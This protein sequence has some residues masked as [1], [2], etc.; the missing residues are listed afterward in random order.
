M[1]E[2]QA[3]REVWNQTAWNAYTSCLS[4][5]SCDNAQSCIDQAAA[6]APEATLDR[7]LD[8]VCSWASRCAGGVLSPSQCVSMLRDLGNSTANQNDA[9]PWNAVRLLQTSAVDCMSHCVTSLSCAQTDFGKASASC[10]AQCGL[11]DLLGSSSS[12]SS[13]SDAGSSSSSNSASCAAQ[14]ST[15]GDHGKMTQNTNGGCDCQC[16]AQ[17]VSSNYICVPGCEV[18][19]CND[20]GTCQDNGV[21]R[22]DQAYY[23][24]PAGSAGACALRPYY[25]DFATSQQI[26]CAVRND[27]VLDCWGQSSSSVLH[28]PTPNSGFRQVRLGGS[29]AQTA[30]CALREDMSVACWAGI[31]APGVALRS[32]SLGGGAACGVQPDDSLHCWGSSPFRTNAPLELSGFRDVAVGDQLACGVRLDGSL[33]CWGSN[34]VV[35]RVPKGI[36]SVAQV[37]VYSGSGCARHDDGSIECFGTAS[38]VG[39]VVPAPNSGF[40]DVSCGEF[41]VC[42]L[43]GDGTALCWGDDALFSAGFNPPAGISDFT[44][45]DVSYQHS[46]G[47]RKDGS[48][49]CW[50]SNNYGQ[51][52]PTRTAKY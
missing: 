49:T 26:T 2:C 16:D 44:N 52:L 17:Y 34:D 22:C 48:I 30:V 19:G 51:A 37:C 38:Y 29:L 33:S 32:L 15:C 9:N 41:Q 24:L 8:D 6:A 5:A 21:C 47:L 39:R 10:G 42:A 50:G 12:D 23:A 27:G 40:T 4:Q 43:R 36:T 46:C 13:S 45:I 3:S 35:A 25:V 7:F 20:H 11:G 18:T 14:H 1:S 31:S 28:L